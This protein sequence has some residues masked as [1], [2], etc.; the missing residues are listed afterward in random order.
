[1][2]NEM[3]QFKQHVRNDDAQDTWTVP[4]DVRMKTIEMVE[5]RVDIHGVARVLEVG[6]R[7]E[8]IVGIAVLQQ[9]HLPMSEEKLTE[10]M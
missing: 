1:M 7:I 8:P 5:Q 9:S 6:F 10:I 4:F 3:H 2:V